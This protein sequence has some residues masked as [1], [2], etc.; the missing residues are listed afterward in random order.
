MKN[1]RSEVKFCI[2]LGAVLLSLGAFA[3]GPPYTGNIY[4]NNTTDLGINFSPGTLETGDEIVLAG[5]LQ[6]NIVNF[7]FDFYGIA[8]AGAPVGQFLGANVQARVRFYTMNGPVNGQGFI[9][10]G[11]THLTP[12][13]DSTFSF[14]PTPRSTAEFSTAFND[15]GPGGASLPI[16][17]AAIANQHITWSVQFSGMVGGDEVGL[18]LYNPPTVGS[19]LPDYWTY[20]AINLWQVKTNALNPMNFG[21]TMSAVPEPSTVGLLICGGLGLLFATRKTRKS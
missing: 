9:T 11:P 7:T 5:T 12:F 15:F 20:D 14:L 3:A 16:P 1:I 18:N 2:G 17:G 13:F 21:A 10:P 8:G 4:Q 6:R 19:S